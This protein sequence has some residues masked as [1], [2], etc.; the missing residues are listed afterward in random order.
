MNR[1]VL[2]NTKTLSPSATHSLIFFLSPFFRIPEKL[3]FPLDS[4]FIF[5]S[6]DFL[7]FHDFRLRYH[8]L[9]AE[10]GTKGERVGESSLFLADPVQ[11]HH[12]S[13][14]PFQLH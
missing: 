8:Q 2:N 9:E 10:R 4:L 7:N 1:H 13:L 11:S 5:D 6:N 12:H 3:L 14:K